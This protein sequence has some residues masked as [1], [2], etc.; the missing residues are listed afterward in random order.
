[1]KPLIAVIGPTATGKS[2][3]AV[4]LAQEFGGE[5]IS[6]DS[7]QIYR[8]M[9]IGTAKISREEQASVPHYL[10]DIKNPDEAFSLAQYQEAAGGII[11]DISNRHKLPILAGGTGQYVRAL[12]EGWS[13]PSVEPDIALRQELEARAAEGE[14]EALYRELEETDPEAAASIDKRNVRRVIRALEVVRTTK[15]PFSEQR[16]KK[17]PAHDSFIIGLTCERKELYRRI[18]R[19]V[20]CMIEQ[21]FIDEVTTL[22][23]MG[24]RPELPSMSGIGYK[25]IIMYLSGALTL[26]E[27][28]YQIKTETHRLVRRQYNWFRLTDER[29]HWL[30]VTG[31]FQE[32]AKRMTGEFL[33]KGR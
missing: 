11:E 29:I 15:K 14:A 33:V 20:D 12:I 30:D 3:L 32:E 17:E 18:D 26:D 23:A 22:L 9:D 25:Q 19:R 6:A 4:L 10:I 21:G 16:L 5:V 7:R 8:Y 28:V 13:I 1:V 27:A 31:D 2:G 24:Y